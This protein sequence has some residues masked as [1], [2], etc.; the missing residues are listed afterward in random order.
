[1]T[2]NQL[3]LW[4]AWI[5]AI[6]FIIRVLKDPQRQTGWLIAAAGVFVAAVMGL[7]LYPRI[8]GWIGFGIWLLAIVAPTIAAQQASTAIQSER[9]GRAAIWSRIA[10]VLHPFDDWPER[11]KIWSIVAAGDRVGAAVTSDRLQAHRNLDTIT[12][13]LT[14]GLIYAIEADWVGLLAW[15]KAHTQAHAPAQ[16][17][18]QTPAQTHNNSAN[19][20]ANTEQDINLIML[21]LHG[22]GET[23]QIDRLVAECDRLATRLEASTIRP[24]T[25]RTWLFA[26]AYTGD[27]EAID[28]LI[29]SRLLDVPDAARDRWRSIARVNASLARDRLSLSLLTERPLRLRIIERLHRSFLQLFRLSSSSPHLTPLL[30][31]LPPLPHTPLKPETSELLLKLERR[32]VEEV[33]YGFHRPL[34]FPLV[35]SIA[36]GLNCLVFALELMLGGSQNAFVLYALGAVVPAAVIENGQT[37]RLLAGTFLHFGWLHLLT[38]M[39]GLFVL[40]Q[41]AERWLGTLRYSLVYLASGVGSMGLVVMTVALGLD[42]DLRFV[43]GASGAVMGVFGAIGAVLWRGYQRDQAVTARQNLQTVAILFVLQSGFDILNPQV[44]A[45]CHLSGAAIGFVVAWLVAPIGMRLRQ[46][47][48]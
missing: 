10:A 21:Y 48:L 36:I 30:E 47:A 11:A 9:Y 41:L 3:L 38:N 25:Y 45:T 6:L 13:R 5:S 12:G 8:S 35:T 14:T 44:C 16:T 37:W 1:M 43:V 2:I 18:A 20:S 4:L 46:P 39:L 23:G 34:Y 40:G 42:A 19:P 31:P 22:L 17:L 32:F 26:F 7:I 29:A 27:L 33:R 28:A 24:R 15:L